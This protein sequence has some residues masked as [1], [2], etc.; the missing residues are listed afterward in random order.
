M[1]GHRIPYA[2]LVAKALCEAG[3][4]VTLFVPEPLRA[5]EDALRDYVHEEIAIEYFSARLNKTGISKVLESK[6]NLL[7]VLR[8]H[9][10]QYM[11]IPTAD[12]L[13]AVF[14]DYQLGFA[15]KLLSQTRIDIC[16]MKTPIHK[17]LKWQAIKLGP[18]QRI[19]FIDPKAWSEFSGQVD[20][21][22]GLCPDPVPD[23]I[24]QNKN[25]ARQKLGLPLESKIIGSVGPQSTRKGT[26]LLIE[27]FLASGF[28]NDVRLLI[29]GKVTS[30]IRNKLDSLSKRDHLNIIVMD[31]F[32][33]EEEFQLAIIASD[34]M[35][36][37]Y[38]DVDR[39]S[40]IVTRCICWERPIVVTNRGWLKWAVEKYD[41]GWT[42]SIDN[43]A[44]FAETL[45]LS[46]VDR[47]DNVESVES[48]DFAK[49]NS[50]VN[51]KSIWKIGPEIRKNE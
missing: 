17:F 13:A 5:K 29:V 25:E 48:S 36:L 41:A 34:V 16:L 42:T 30:E 8:T 10:P 40:G 24:C 39:P 21:R 45:K 22:F 49:F 26:D 20:G 15:S 33:S 43:C 7:Q 35:A 32:V 27:A 11:A 50:E 23:Q 44:E 46:L 1:T 28:N 47:I 18:W 9:S 51:Y 37:P 2:S 31:R 19:L 3:H 12:G 6:A 4:D 14:P 38:R